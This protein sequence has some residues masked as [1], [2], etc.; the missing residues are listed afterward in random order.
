MPYK[1]AITSTDG[2][3]VDAH[4][5]RADCFYIYDVDDSGAYSQTGLRSVQP[6]PEI[7]GGCRHNEQGIKP[8]INA[9][10]DCRYILTA[11]I[12]KRPQMLLNRSGIT[13]LESPSE[14]SEAIGKLH[15]YHIKTNKGEKPK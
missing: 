14:L 15:K 6:L 13:A 3:T 12:G 8:L 2:Q 5:G 7:Q 10:S 4:F 9:L 11:Q 1:I